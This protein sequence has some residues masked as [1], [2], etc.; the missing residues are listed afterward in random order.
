MLDIKLREEKIKEK[1][2]QTSFRDFIKEITSWY[3]F[4]LFRYQGYI[5]RYPEVERNQ[6]VV[7]DVS[8]SM[9]NN[10]I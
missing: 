10:C 7:A 5:S 1:R 6:N 9:Q 8:I 3:N 2:K 4:N